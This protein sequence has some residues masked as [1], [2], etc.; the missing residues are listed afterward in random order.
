MEI[1][2][3]VQDRKALVKA[4]SEHL[5]LKATYMGPP[6]FAYQVGNLTI[7]RDGTVETEDE[8]QH[9][10]AKAVM[11]NLGCIVD[12]A[13]VDDLQV[14]VPIEG[15]DGFALRNLIFLLSS[16][17]YL[18]NR[19][20]Q[21]EHFHVSNEL[22]DALK[23]GECSRASEF[24]SIIDSTQDGLKG[25]AFADDNAEFTFPVSDDPV[26][27]R[28]LVTL[29]ALM[30]NSAK[31]AKRVDPTNQVVENEKYYLRI[32]LIHL[33]LSGRGGQETRRALLDG[34]KGHTAFRTPEDAARFSANQ[35]A[36]REAAKAA[37]AALEVSTPA[38][39]STAEQDADCAA[40]KGL[41]P[42]SESGEG[43]A[44]MP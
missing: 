6:T 32:W 15:M 27:N 19:V 2:G 14:Q 10:Q 8:A 39:I 40:E 41:E 30:V 34:L 3:N 13:V 1:K 35:K 23:T 20:L 42:L 11:I 4:L 33:G 31:Q 22:V 28:A 25:L 43:P 9:A 18:L 24:H 17:Q 12:E 38:P 44:E 7:G 5:G 37:A 26:K 21:R 16:K 29:A 36:K